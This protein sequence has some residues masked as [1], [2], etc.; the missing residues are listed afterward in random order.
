MQI[1]SNENKNFLINKMNNQIPNDIEDYFDDD[2]ISRLF[3]INLPNRENKLNKFYINEY[4]FIYNYLDI[5]KD[6]INNT[7]TIKVTYCNSEE[8]KENIYTNDDTFINNIKVLYN[9][10]YISLSTFFN[11]NSIFTSAH[12]NLY[13]NSPYK[14]H[15][16]ILFEKIALFKGFREVYYSYEYSNYKTKNNV[17]KKRT[18]IPVYCMYYKKYLN[19]EN[20]KKTIHTDKELN[21]INETLSLRSDMNYNLL[22]NYFK[23]LKISMFNINYMLNTILTKNLTKN[24]LDDLCTS[25]EKI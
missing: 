18:I 25:S 19:P 16:N 15:T 9:N 6:L 1:F 23:L 24:L 21:E 2:F 12:Y 17:L 11:S 3:E 10:E 5:F 4:I 13:N 8:N 14:F 20:V 22:V 7:T